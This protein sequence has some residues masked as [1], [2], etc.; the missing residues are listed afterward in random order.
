M[1][2][3]I[4]SMTERCKLDLATV[5][6]ILHAESEIHSEFTR[7]SGRVCIIV[8]G[9]IPWCPLPEVND[10]ALLA[11]GVVVHHEPTPANPSRLWVRDS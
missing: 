9:D 3:H 7:F 1:V 5:L 8:L 4:L 10:G 6:H 2:T 11:S